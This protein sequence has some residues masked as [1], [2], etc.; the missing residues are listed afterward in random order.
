MNTFTKEELIQI[1]STATSKVKL[2]ESLGII[3]KNGTKMNKE[4]EEYASIIGYD[5]STIKIDNQRKYKKEQAEIEYNK[6]PK[7]CAYCGN[8]FS[9][10]KRKARFCNY[11]C[12]AKYNNIH[13]N[14]NVEGKTKDAICID[15]GKEF[16]VSIYRDLS[17]CR[18]EKC[19]NKRLAENKINN[20]IKHI[21][22][23]NEYIKD[24]IFK[25]L[26]CGKEYTPSLLDSGNY[27][28][29]KFCS[30]ECRKKYTSEKI[31]ESI[32]KRIEEGVFSGWKSRNII[33]YA[34]R[35]WIQVLN[36]NNIQYQ[37]EFYL[38]KKYFLDFLIKK[39]NKKIDLEIDGKQ[40]TYQERIEHDK[41]RDEYVTN[42][43][44]IVYRIPWNSIS[45]EKGSLEM[46]EKIDKFLEFYNSL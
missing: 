10:E 32:Q 33:S 9:Y 34:E 20:T 15:C 38:D 13:R 23:T 5:T 28:A 40:H 3:T 42:V 24:K 35:F 46:K 18:C 29:S 27:S 16:K 45:S 7:Y 21:T 37:K 26:V 8:K 4:I 36:N 11:S 17:A 43:G 6:N 41:E 22:H 1:F 25:C 14:L 44:Y 19:K 2:A 30:D 31:K 12:A 39:N